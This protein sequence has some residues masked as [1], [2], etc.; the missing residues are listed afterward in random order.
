MNTDHL[1][2]QAV[3]IF[4]A[5]KDVKEIIIAA[6]GC[7]FT[8]ENLHKAQAHATSLAVKDLVTF[9]R[10]DVLPQPKAFN[11]GGGAAA[12]EPTSPAAPVEDE[13]RVALVA[14]Y[15]TLF[16]EKPHHNIGLETLKSRIAT[17]EQEIAQTQV[18]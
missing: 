4:N 5:H 18:N 12:P 8:L 16:G 15:E 14:K 13:E 10:A 17:K 6:D 2:K 1:K 7:A 3:K 11:A 9:K